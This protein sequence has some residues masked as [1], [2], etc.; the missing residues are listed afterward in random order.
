MSTKKII[1]IIAGILAAL[2]LIVAL[3]VGG[4]V[5]F[6]FH[7][8]AKS[9]AADTARTFLRNNEI[10]K[11]DI[12]EVKDFGSFVTGNVNVQNTDGEASLH[13]KVIGE[14]RTVNAT[15][16]LSYRN[17][18]SWRGS[19]GRFGWTVQKNCFWQGRGPASAATT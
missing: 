2:G 3:F 5:W 10:L 17:N 1:L 7:T 9:E 14:K 11:Q 6:A 18:R 4:I 8:I 19:G 15:V 16:D 12:G 13:L